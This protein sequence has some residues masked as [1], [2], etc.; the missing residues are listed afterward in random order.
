VLYREGM[1]APQFSTAMVLV[2]AGVVSANVAAA[3]PKRGDRRI[4]RG[5][6]FQKLDSGLQRTIDGESHK[7]G[8]LRVIIRTRSGVDLRGSKAFDRLIEKGHN[9]RF[10][11]SLVGGVL[12]DVKD[13]DLEQLAN[14]PDVEGI[15]I[16]APVKVH[17]SASDGCS[18]WVTGYGTACSDPTSQF[19]VERGAMGYRSTNWDAWDVGVAV[20][21]SGVSASDDLR[22]TASYDFRSGVAVQAAPYDGYGHGTHVAGLIASSG[23]HSKG[24]Y[25][26]VAPGAKIIALR[27]LDSNGAGY[28]SNVIK[29]VEFAVANRTSLGIHIINLSLG[30]P[31]YEPAANDPL[32]L[33]VESAVRAGIV[34]V[35]SAGNNGMDDAGVVGYAGIS[36]PGNAPSA[37][38]VGTVD[39]KNTAWPY[40]DT[41]APYSSRGPSWFDGFAKPDILAPGHRL[42]APV[43]SSTKL[44]QQLVSQRVSAP[45]GSSAPTTHLRLSGTSM[46]TAV[47][48]G[49]VAAMLDVQQLTFNRKMTPNAIKAILQATALPLPGADKLTQ[50]NGRLNMLGALMVARRVNP[51]VPVGQMWLTSSL[52]NTTSIEGQPITWA[53]HVVWGDH[54]VWG[55]G[56]TYNQQLWANHVVWG[57]S[58]PWLGN[59]TVDPNHIVW[60][61][62]ATWANHI[63]WGDSLL[64][65][66]DGTHVVWGEHIVWGDS[67]S[68]A[69]H[70]VWGDLT[71]G[72]LTK[73]SSVLGYAADTVPG[74]VYAPVD[75]VPVTWDPFEV[76]AGAVPPAEAPP[77]ETVP[78]G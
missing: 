22:I 25:Q 69:N 15:S 5:A 78:V 23:S 14:L 52:S 30:H 35:V 8:H 33:A 75:D 48:S 73:I 3:E 64:G 24:Y 53:S 4:T 12:A 1:R 28:T 47:V 57:D 63:V 20:I 2:L 70:I 67:V 19:F 60:G 72:N 54:I 38:T 42:V 10:G 27:V 45:W 58:L 7:G 39:H 34:V 41:V 66:V 68:D 76:P 46:S 16:D 36:S 77:A 65:I 62:T 13:E 49:V 18:T 31:I 51:W 55:D 9:G 50:G 32:V 29:A 17:Q 56:L 6:W 11:L 21:D 71:K 26:G 74:E 40:D 61:D 59:M 37:I 43:P 44:Y